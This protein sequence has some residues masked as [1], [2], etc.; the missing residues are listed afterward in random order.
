MTRTLHTRRFACPLA[1]PLATADGRIEHREGWLVCVENEGTVGVG[2]ATPLAGW[3]ESQT[4]CR[5]ALR[6]ADPECGR[7]PS[8][9]TPAARHGVGLAVR[10][11]FARRRG[12]S[13]AASLTRVEPSDRV[14][15]NAT[16]GDGDVGETVA[17]AAEA[18]ESGFR[19]IKLKVGAREPSADIERVRRVENRVADDVRLRADA[20]GAYDRETARR[21]LSALDGVVSYVEQP[22]AAD[23]LDGLV[24]LR[25]AGAPVAADETLRH[26]GPRAVLAAGAADVVIC[27]PMVLGGLERTL[28]VAR[29]ARAQGVTPVVTTTVDAVIAR[30]A[31]VHAA[32][33]L[34]G[35][36]EAADAHPATSIGGDAPDDTDPTRPPAHGLATGDRLAGEP[37]GGDG[38]LP[39][40]VPVRN[41]QIEPPSGP[42]L[43]D[44]RLDWA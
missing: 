30:T 16:V 18:V 11:A 27:K 4:A 15:V 9:R 23:D 43:A 8:A 40:P 14:P 35:E 36:R 3:T 24:A 42:G 20:N 34:V 19:T 22:V 33:V 17:A 44:G 38:P 37:Q 2:E 10:D 41:G 29:A 13:V 25:D 7:L 21:V 1:T 31:A 5:G 6:A 12:E 39:D 26:H 28:A 32:S